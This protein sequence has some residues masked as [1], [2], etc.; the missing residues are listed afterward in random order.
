MF[1]VP[2][3][4]SSLDL[5]AAG[6]RAALPFVL[7]ATETA[8][9]FAA[10]AQAEIT[11][12]PGVCLTGLGPGVASAVNG[13]AC[14]SLERAPLILVSDTHPTAPAG[15]FAHQRIDHRAVLAPLTKWSAT[16]SAIDAEAV[17]AAALARALEAPRGPVHLD[18]PSDI[19]SRPAQSHP[20]A[21]RRTDGEATPTPAG[22]RL[23]A[24][25]RRP[26]LIAGLH[27]RQ[28]APAIRAFCEAQRVPAMVTYKAKGV[29]PDRNRWFAGVFTNGALEADLTDRADLLITVGL[30]RVELLPRPWVPRQPVI[31]LADD[32]ASHL[33]VVSDDLA[34]DWNPD[35][36]QQTVVEQLRRLESRGARLTA[37]RLVRGVHDAFPQARVTVDAGAHMFAATLLWPVDEPNGM[38]ISNGLSTM[39]FAVPAALGAALLDR[40]RP[41]VALTGDGGLLMCAGELLPLV[42]ERLHVVVVVFNDASLSLI[43]IKQRE[44]QFASAGVTLGCVDWTAVAAGLGLAAHRVGTD[45][46]LCRALT[47]AAGHDGPTLIDAHIDPA[48][49]ARMLRTIRG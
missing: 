14:A 47:A 49:Y 32:V 15:G 20:A 37:D 25:S 39:G 4:G 19:V 46:E 11:G 40:P 8:G 7:N 30:D 13:V 21:V 9:A 43:D 6:S 10:I 44:R 1:G 16:L 28:H 23:T 27:A 34:S 22:G 36:L 2:G 42:R 38:L 24:I 12:A 18:C 26:L 3:G 33:Q 29:V 45:A 48:P 5:I 41:V 35:M 17:V 31:A